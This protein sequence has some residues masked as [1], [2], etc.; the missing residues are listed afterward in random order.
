MG[1][2]EQPLT[3]ACRF[4]KLWLE[5]SNIWLWWQYVKDL[6][7]VKTLKNYY[8]FIFLQ[9]GSQHC[10]CHVPYQIKLFNNFH[11]GKKNNFHLGIKANILTRICWSPA[12]H[13]LSTFT[14]YHSSSGNPVVI[15]AA[16]VLQKWP[17]T[18]G[19]WLCH[20]FYL[21]C[22]SLTFYH[23]LPWGFQNSV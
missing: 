20:S 1:H 4:V 9:S 8:F 21:E 2:S 12:L 18:E 14:S 6:I 19:L 15:S 7:V 22:S 11:L 23:S 17:P 13:S 16:Q 3:Q 5:G 10:N